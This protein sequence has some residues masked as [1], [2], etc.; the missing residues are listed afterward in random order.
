MAF[1]AFY[2]LTPGWKFSFPQSYSVPKTGNKVT[3]LW[4]RE[5]STFGGI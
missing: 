4:V 2:F 3:P 1:A 5:Y